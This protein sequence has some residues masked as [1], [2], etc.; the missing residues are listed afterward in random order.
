[1]ILKVC[2]FQT[3][4]EWLANC[5]NSY[6]VPG[7]KFMAPS[8]IPV[9]CCLWKNVC[10]HLLHS[11][12]HWHAPRSITNSGFFSCLIS[13]QSAFVRTFLMLNTWINFILHCVNHKA[14][15]TW[16][17]TTSQG[18]SILFLLVTKKASESQIYLETAANHLGVFSEEGPLLL[19]QKC[20]KVNKKQDRIFSSKSEVTESW[21]PL[22]KLV[23]QESG[24]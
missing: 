3:A 5:W 11:P 16:M 18:L 8:C 7:M 2:W 20:I 24:D 14:V 22:P 21:C 1:M 17:Y 10:F 13:S 23:C 15:N 4:L 6:S 9:S 19:L 12:S